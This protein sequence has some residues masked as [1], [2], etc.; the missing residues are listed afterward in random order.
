M[1]AISGGSAA[2]L[3]LLSYVCRN[4]NPASRMNAFL[5]KHPGTTSGS[6]LSAR[7]RYDILLSCLLHVQ[8]CIRASKVA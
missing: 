2:Q 4:G 8:L 1:G 3:M 7:H 5:A 6:K